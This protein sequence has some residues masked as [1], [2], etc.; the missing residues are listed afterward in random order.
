MKV[1]EIF[2]S[3]YSRKKRLKTFLVTALYENLK[4]MLKKTSLLKSDHLNLKFYFK[5]LAADHWK[6]NM[7]YIK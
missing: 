4:K 5:Q 2:L 1:R 6:S 3:K 7:I